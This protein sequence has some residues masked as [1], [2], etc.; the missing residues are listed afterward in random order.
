MDEKDIIDVEVISE[1]TSEVKK[2]EKPKKVNS[3]DHSRQVE[4][5][6]RLSAIF[7]RIG[8]GPMFLFATIGLVFS[9]LYQNHPS[10]LSFLVLLIVG[11]SLAGICLISLVLGYLFR[12]A[13]ISHMR[14][15]PNYDHYFH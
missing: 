9:I 7:L 8:R 13:Q 11:W 1:T 15:D 4:F 14:K 10:N 5:Y 6:G 3:S 12:R 2:E